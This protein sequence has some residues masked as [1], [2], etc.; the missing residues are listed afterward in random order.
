MRQEE[1]YGITFPLVTTSSGAKMGKTA[2]GAIWLDSERTSPYDYYQYWVN[3]DDR[4]VKRFLCLFTF[5][6]IEEIKEVEHLQNAELNSAKA[7][8][9][10]EATRLCHGE[11]EAEKAF[12]AAAAVFGSKTIH[13]AIL[14]SSSIPRESKLKGVDSSVPSSVIQEPDL[15]N[16]IP[17]FKLYQQVGLAQSA[18]SARRLIEQGGAYI[19]GQRVEST[20]YMVTLSDV[21]SDEIMLRAGKKKYHKIIISSMNSC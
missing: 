20:D 14:P 7:I 19:N 15:A 8:L 1:A 12:N 21:A 17:A 13:E 6:P 9:A 4:D 2:Q 11:E 16:G 18:S 10:Y 5:L 3:T